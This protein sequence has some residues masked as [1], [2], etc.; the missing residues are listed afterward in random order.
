L[1]QNT[2]LFWLSGDARPEGFL[3]HARD[4]MF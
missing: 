4:E 2:D 3:A 1:R